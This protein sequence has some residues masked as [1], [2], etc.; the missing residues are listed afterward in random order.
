MRIVICGFLEGIYRN[1]SLYL[2]I[3]LMS[4][5]NQFKSD[6]TPNAE[7]LNRY[8][9]VGQ[10]DVLDSQDV[11]NMYKGKDKT[12]WKKY[13]LYL[14]RMAQGSDLGAREAIF[15]NA[16]KELT[17][18]G[19]DLETAQDYAA[20]RAHQY[21]PYQQVGT[22]R[23]LAYLRRM[24]PFI[25]PPIQGLARDIAAARGR[26]GNISRADGKKALAWRLAKYT[27]VTAAYAAFMSGDDDY[28]SKT[29]D[30]QDNNF[31][32]GGTRVPVPAEIRPLKVAI[33]RG[34]RAYINTPGAD[35]D[36]PEIAAAIIRKFWEVAAGFAPIP[37]IARPIGENIANYDVFTGRP[38]V[39]PG[40][41]R[42]EPAYQY[43]EN[44]SE[45]AKVIGA[46]LN[47][48]PMKID[49]LIKGY[50]GYMGTTLAQ[51]TNY[52]SSDRPAPPIN[53][54]LFIG[55]ML[56]GEH[57]SGAKGDFYELY[58]KTSTVKATAQALKEAGDSEGL[59]NYMQKNQGY[60]AVAPSVNNLHNQLTK[61]RQYKKQILA[62]GMTPEEK[63]EALDSLS[64]SENNM[65]SNIKD[66]H[67]QALEINNQN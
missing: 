3:L 38:V 64:D 22:S 27:M 34:T 58:D 44:T 5:N 10:K 63:R 48:S 46:Q 43:S 31:F 42:K 59:Q 40:Q 53:Q 66:L 55:S 45:V 14:E 15:K 18:Q 51:M 25:N 9:I 21:M 26:V 1:K 11:I 29:D 39:G 47:Y 20:V 52:L 16:V 65:L 7:L 2:I 12:G 13:V 54:M 67:R 23:S 4:L 19:Y 8:G 24:L 6:R 35:V 28:E 37:T 17:D 41:Q 50:G 60:L 36:N 56:E 49:H 30:Q 62:S 32:I 61:L 57:A 33:E